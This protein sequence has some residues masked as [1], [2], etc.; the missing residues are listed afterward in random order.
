MARL[1][2]TEIARVNHGT[3]L[4]SGTQW[5]VESI[6]LR[7]REDF[8]NRRPYWILVQ[9]LCNGLAAASQQFKTR[10]A[11]LRAL[12]D[13]SRKILPSLSLERFNPR[14]TRS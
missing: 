9:Y 5:P 2:T 13:V 14:G 7:Q 10:K 11:A 4:L 12:E 6:V 1:I 3:R 8:L